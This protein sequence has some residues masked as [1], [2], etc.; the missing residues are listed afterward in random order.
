M[1]D[2]SVR[3]MSFD[4]EICEFESGPHDERPIIR[5]VGQACIWQAEQVLQRTD[6]VHGCRKPFRK[7]PFSC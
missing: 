2:V 5:H 7:I 1:T 4:I 3:V 6:V